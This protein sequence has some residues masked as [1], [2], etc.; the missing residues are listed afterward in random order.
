[1]TFESCC[2]LSGIIVYFQS[3]SIDPA[4]IISMCRFYALGSPSVAKFPKISQTVAVASR[5]CPSKQNPYQYSRRNPLSYAMGGVFTATSILA[6]FNGT[7]YRVYHQL[8]LTVNYLLFVFS[9]RFLPPSM[10][11]PFP[12]IPGIFVNH[13]YHPLVRTVKFHIITLRIPQRLFERRSRRSI[14]KQSG[15]C[16]HRTGSLSSHRLKGYAVFSGFRNC[17]D[18]SSDCRVPSPNPRYK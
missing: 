3:D 12:E 17:P 10:T 7:R 2:K 4:F 18:L 5:S 6:E 16:S 14:N 15:R 8:Y 9:G 13:L 11:V 1:M